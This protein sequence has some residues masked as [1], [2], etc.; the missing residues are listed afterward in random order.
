MCRLDG[1]TDPRH[2]RRA[3]VL[4]PRRGSGS[5]VEAYL[6]R[7]PSPTAASPPEAAADA[8]GADGRL[9]WR[10]PHRRQIN[11]RGNCR[12]RSVRVQA[13]HS[14]TGLRP[15]QAADGWPARMRPSPA[16]G[17]APR[18]VADPRR[19]RRRA[20][21]RR[22]AARPQSADP[23]G[24][25]RDATGGAHGHAL[26]TPA[27]AARELLARGTS[28]DLPSARLRPGR[29]VQDRLRRSQLLA[30]CGRPSD[31]PSFE[32]PRVLNG[33][34]EHLWAWPRRR[35]RGNI[36]SPS[37]FPYSGQARPSRGYTLMRPPLARA[38]LAACRI[39]CSGPRPPPPKS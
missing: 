1:R 11:L 38:L 30:S 33:F 12:R 7:A 22:A 13:L 6:R 28:I 35:A 26:I 25:D 23:C 18:R 27:R 36:A 4:R 31:V 3:P 29:C 5:M 15:A 37:V 34:A 21:D 39:A 32:S 8:S 24:R 19:R 2:D 16:R 17:S 10:A 14:V 9:S 20:R